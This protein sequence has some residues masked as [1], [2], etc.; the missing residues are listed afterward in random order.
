LEHLFNQ[1]LLIGNKKHKKHLVL[2]VFY[3]KH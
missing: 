1:A 3:Y 2:G